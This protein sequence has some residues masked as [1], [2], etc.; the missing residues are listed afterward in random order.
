MKGN[1][2]F[3]VGKRNVNLAIKITFRWILNVV[4]AYL[5]RSGGITLGVVPKSIIAKGLPGTRSV[6]VK[7]VLAAL[8]STVFLRLLWTIFVKKTDALRI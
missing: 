5:I 2:R 6:N 7:P 3:N 1:A 4:A 8:K